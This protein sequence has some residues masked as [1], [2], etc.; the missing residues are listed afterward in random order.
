MV[1]VTLVVLGDDPARGVVLPRL[2][3]DLVITLPRT[4]VGGFVEV[5]EACR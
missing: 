1:Q 2:T 3:I 5:A 4:G